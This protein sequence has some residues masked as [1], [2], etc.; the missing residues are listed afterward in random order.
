MSYVVFIAFGNE[1]GEFL[2][3]KRS[4]TTAVNPE[5]SNTFLVVRYADGAVIGESLETSHRRCVVARGA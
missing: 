4:R 2:G 3:N 5:Q 1:F